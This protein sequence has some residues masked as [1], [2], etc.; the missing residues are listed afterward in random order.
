MFVHKEKTHIHAFAGLDFVNG[1]DEVL[2]EGKIYVISEFN[3]ADAKYSYS[4]VSN[5]KEIYF[6]KRTNMKLIE[7][8]DDMIPQHKFELVAFSTL[9]EKVGNT[10]ILTG[11]IHNIQ[12]SHRS[13]S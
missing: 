1:I 8:D 5:K 13:W 4:A 2:E 7:E 9:K 10:K 12:H 6:L 3:V 11:K